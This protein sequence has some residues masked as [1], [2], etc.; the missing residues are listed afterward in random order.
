[1]TEMLSDWAFYY[2]MLVFILVDEW[3]K[4]HQR[5]W[6]VK[7]ILL[8]TILTFGIFMLKLYKS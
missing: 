6:Y 3:C 7:F 8:T 1:M 2:G 4:V 5:P